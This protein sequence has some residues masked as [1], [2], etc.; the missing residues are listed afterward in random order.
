VTL[1]AT[2]GAFSPD[3]TRLLLRGY[4]GARVYGWRNGG[5][6]PI[7]SVSVPVQQQGESVTFTPDGRTLMFG[8]EGRGSTVEP[9]ELHGDLLPERAAEQADAH[10]T[11]ASGT[12]DGDGGADAPDEGNVLLGAAVFAAA[13][14]LW[15]GLRRIV[16][17]RD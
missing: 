1:W 7:G 6:E 2:D 11:S 4:F 8:S 5:P 14:A 3:G 17:R 10:G 13:V 16:R 12:A 9:V 15:M